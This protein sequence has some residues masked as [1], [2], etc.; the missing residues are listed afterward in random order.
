MDEDELLNKIEHYIEIGAI[1][2]VGYDE[3]GEALFEL[4][5]DMTLEKAP[6]LWNAHEEYVEDSLLS[7]LEKDLM[8]VEYNENLEA[9]MIFSEEG[10]D[11]AKRMGII[12]LEDI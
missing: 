4:N 1:K 10:Y 11:M 2:F 8:H 9:T 12:P 7:L 6:E 3:F 5:E